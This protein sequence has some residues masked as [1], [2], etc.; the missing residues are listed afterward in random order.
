MKNP[1]FRSNRREFLRSTGLALA[2]S[3]AISAFPAPA[4]SREKSP[5]SKLNVAC[6]GVSGRAAAS[7]HGVRT[8]NI[9]AMCDVYAK[10]LEPRKE[11]FPS[12]KFYA[13]FRIM[14]DELGDKIDAVT[15]GT[16]D[17]T[18]AVASV[19][20]MKKG[21]HCYCEK[22]LTH[23]VYEAKRMM[24]ITREKKLI[25]QMGTQI[26][27][28][29]NYR[30]VVEHIQAGVIGEVDE[31]YVWMCGKGWGGHKLPT[32]TPPVPEGLDWDL[33]LGPALE[34]PYH[35]TYVPGGWRR[36]WAF[37][38]G[39]LGDMACHLMDLPFWA[40]DLS[41]P[42][43]IEA[44]GPVPPDPEAA[45]ASVSVQYAFTRKSGKDLRLHW[46]DGEERPA[47]LQ[48]KG[49]PN[50]GMGI[51]FIGSEGMLM[52]DYGRLL[53]FP[54]EKF[55]G[56]ERPPQSIP[57][58]IGH[59]EEWIKAIKEN[60]PEECLCRFDYSAPLTISV[61]LGTVAFRTGEKLN[62]DRETLDVPGVPAAAPIL[63]QPRREGWGID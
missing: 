40:F 22:P 27:A 39:T 61:L 63:K 14:Y 8:E 57:N 10:N 19:I 18:H 26:H 46:Y 25:T 29:P 59:Y 45:P 33:W 23:D 51:L 9:I 43:S 12:A 41:Y 4:F 60:K 56:L 17:H 48:E 35:P 34:R 20:G 16:P 49:L 62:W 6:I 15:V 11:Q 28:E 2:G 1:N 7:V 36:W 50:W 44:S 21:I 32:D 54:E 5:S 52:A 53:L 55:A 24:E 42:R 31:V 58:S 47:Y 3:T 37:G 30:R 38:N 13:D